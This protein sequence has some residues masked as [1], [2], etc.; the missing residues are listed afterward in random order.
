[1]IA[2]VQA[3]ASFNAPPFSIWEIALP[4]LILPPIAHRSR[5]RFIGVSAQ[6]L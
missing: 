4:A 5:W 3:K 2:K 6:L 1:M